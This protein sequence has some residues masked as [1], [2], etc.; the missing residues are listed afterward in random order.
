MINIEYTQ[1]NN[2]CNNIILL[3]TMKCIKIYSLYNF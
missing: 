2:K 3:Y 1:Y